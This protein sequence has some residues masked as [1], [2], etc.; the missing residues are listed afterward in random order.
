MLLFCSSLVSF[1]LPRV[2]FWVYLVVVVAKTNVLLHSLLPLISCNMLNIIVYS[3]YRDISNIFPSIYFNMIIGCTKSACLAC[4]DDKTC[5]TH[6]EVREHAQWK[7][8][9][10]AGTTPLQLLVKEKRSKAIPAGRFKE[11]DFSYL[12]DTVVLWDL[13]QYYANAAWREDAIRKSKKRRTRQLNHDLSTT[14]GLAAAVTSNKASNRKTRR[15][16]CHDIM[17]ALYQKSLS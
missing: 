2:S 3:S 13:D 9:V 12:G 1:L 15:Q 16:R 5:V 17:E 14:G 7:E 10:L 6:K 4:C 8:Q 11:Q